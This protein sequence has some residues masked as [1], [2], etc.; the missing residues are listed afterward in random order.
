MAKFDPKDVQAGEM[1][2]IQSKSAS[3]G[4]ATHARED[5]GLS[6]FCAIRNP[7]LKALVSEDATAAVLAAEEM[8]L[9]VE[10]GAVKRSR[11]LQ[12]WSE[13]LQVWT[14]RWER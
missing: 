11:A 4:G 7:H 13:R 8:A 9:L 10:T 5:R 1:L 3:T 6:K 12:E 2:A 14:K